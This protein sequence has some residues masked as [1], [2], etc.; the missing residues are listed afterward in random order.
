MI[1]TELEGSYVQELRYLGAYAYAVKTSNP[2]SIA[3]I[4]LNKE[5]LEKVDMSFEECSYAM[6]P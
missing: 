2:N 3:D 6:L 4:K 1:K 5:E